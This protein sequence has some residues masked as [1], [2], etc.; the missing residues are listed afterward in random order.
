MKN[1]ELEYWIDLAKQ[2]AT[3][4]HAG[5]TRRGGDPYITHPER[6]ANRVSDRLRRLL[7]YMM[8]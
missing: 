4:A 5:Q 7:G 6:I 8:S 2:V 3:K 1:S